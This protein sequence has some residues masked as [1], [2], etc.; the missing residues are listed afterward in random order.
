MALP[1]GG[2]AVGRRGAFPTGRRPGFMVFAASGSA[3]AKGGI[4]TSS[5][6]DDTTPSEPFE[7]S[8]PSEL[9]REAAP[10]AI[11]SPLN[12]LNPLHPLHTMNTISQKFP[13]K[14]LDRV[15][16]GGYYI[17]IFRQPNELKQAMNETKGLLS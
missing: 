16:R 12:P 8:E 17:H 4:Q 9:C 7:P 3:A 6:T 10:M 1:S 13:Q 2:G 14:V 11:P 15:T 5:S